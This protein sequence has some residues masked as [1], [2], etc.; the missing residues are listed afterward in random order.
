M[1]SIRLAVSFALALFIASAAP[2]AQAA[3]L[4]PANGAQQSAL[5]TTTGANSWTVPAGVTL[6]WAYG[7]AGGGGGGGGQTTTTTAGGG[8]GASGM[9]TGGGTSLPFPL[10]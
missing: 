3:P 8:G 9:C 2:Q 7:C 6:V 5:F 4:F 10:N 1:K